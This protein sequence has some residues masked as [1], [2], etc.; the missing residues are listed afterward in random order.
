M[1]E[2]KKETDNSICTLYEPIVEVHMLCILCNLYDI[3]MS[4]ITYM[5]HRPYVYKHGKKN[6]QKI[7]VI[8]L[9]GAMKY[10]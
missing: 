3:Y 5:T 6:I 10:M 7:L 1:N 4:C 2:F 9:R 8:I